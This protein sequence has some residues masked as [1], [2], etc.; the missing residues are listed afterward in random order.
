[1]AEFEAGSDTVIA[2]SEY[3]S[4]LLLLAATMERQQQEQLVRRKVDC[5]AN[6][7]NAVTRIRLGK[8]Y[9]KI[10][11]GTSGK[12]MV[13]RETGEVFG[14]K[15]YGKIHKGHKYGTLDTISEWYWGLYYP[16]Q[17]EAMPVN[18]K[19]IQVSIKS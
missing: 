3:G 15:G 5:A 19:G 17:Y 11:V 14:I 7:A 16:K 4:K 9:D 8:K 6:M 13:E 10:D 18:L 12:L 2:S 1:M